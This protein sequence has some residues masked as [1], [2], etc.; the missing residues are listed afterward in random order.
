MKALLEQAR[1]E[2][3]GI[4]AFSVGNMKWSKERLRRQKS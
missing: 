1:G 3:R 2:A 4:G